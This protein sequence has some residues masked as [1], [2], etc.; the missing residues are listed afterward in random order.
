MLM[1]DSQHLEPSLK[2]LD[3]PA[4]RFCWRR[5]GKKRKPLCISC[6]QVLLTS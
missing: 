5:S 6:L 1:F 4:P 3:F 2:T